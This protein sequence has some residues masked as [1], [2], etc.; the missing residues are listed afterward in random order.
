MKTERQIREEKR[1]I[2]KLLLQQISELF[3]EYQDEFAAE[4]MP[5]TLTALANKGLALQEL[6]ERLGFSWNEVRNDYPRL[7]VIQIQT[8]SGLLK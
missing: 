4:S 3:D 7:H 6:T 1:L 8:V 2:R 5:E